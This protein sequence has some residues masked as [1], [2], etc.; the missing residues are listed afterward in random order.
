MI[1][2]SNISS[3]SFPIYISTFPSRLRKLCTRSLACLDVH[4]CVYHPPSIRD[5][6]IGYVMQRK[7]NLLLWPPCCGPPMVRCPGVQDFIRGLVRKDRAHVCRLSPQYYILDGSAGAVTF[8][9]IPC[10]HLINNYC[11]MLARKPA[12]CY[13]SDL[14]AGKKM[15]FEKAFCY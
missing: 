3:I 11:Q 13:S 15:Q 10:Q 14:T 1:C 4:A 9:S 2:P 12:K 7:G 6:W 5:P 8:G